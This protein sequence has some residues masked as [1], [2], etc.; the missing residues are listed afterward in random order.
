MSWLNILKCQHCIDLVNS[1]A[2]QFYSQFLF[3]SGTAFSHRVTAGGRR[4]DVTGCLSR[5]LS[6][7]AAY[8]LM[9]IIRLQCC[10]VGFLASADGTR[11]K[12]NCK[13]FLPITRM[14]YQHN[15]TF[16]TVCT[17]CCV[18]SN[19]WQYTSCNDNNEHVEHV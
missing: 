3:Q 18:R 8:L 7:V 16:V 14:T 1:L 13:L 5:C 11:R 4:T 15:I 6:L 2:V 19:I 12:V 17:F 9:T 10:V